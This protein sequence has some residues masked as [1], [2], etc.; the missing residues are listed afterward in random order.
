MCSSR[1]VFS[2]FAKTLVILPHPTISST[3]TLVQSFLEKKK[4]SF[5]SESYCSL[6]PEASMFCG[7]LVEIDGVIGDYI[8]S[9]ISF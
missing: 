9:L 8:F 2:F 5:K 3:P 6:E 7:F 1:A 4:I